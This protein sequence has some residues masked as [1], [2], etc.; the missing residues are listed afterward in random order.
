MRVGGTDVPPLWVVGRAARLDGSRRKLR[1]R[2]DRVC[3]LERERE[4][5]LAPRAEEV[6]R[7]LL[8][9]LGSQS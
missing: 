3:D 5:A 7:R 2:L 1:A 9:K 4:D 8:I 6:A